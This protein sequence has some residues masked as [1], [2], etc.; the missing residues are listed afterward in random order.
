MREF[1]QNLVST[2]SRQPLSQCK[3]TFCYA[4]VH[5]GWFYEQDYTKT[6]G[7]AG[8]LMEDGPPTSR[9]Q[10]IFSH[11]QLKPTVFKTLMFVSQEKKRIEKKVLYFG[12]LST[13]LL[14]KRRPM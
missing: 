14:D 4:C 8:T 6:S 1:A 10:G 9:V 12:F 2:V 13:N 3:L 7:F 11:S 5:D